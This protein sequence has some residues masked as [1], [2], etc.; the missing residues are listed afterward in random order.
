MDENKQPEQ[1]PYFTI[2]D[3]DTC[4]YLWTVLQNVDM[5]ID[6]PQ[7]VKDLYDHCADEVFEANAF[8]LF[9]AAGYVNVERK[10]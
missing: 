7:Q 1:Q 6:A 4:A 3:P 9:S 8:M 5:Q 2:D 10:Q